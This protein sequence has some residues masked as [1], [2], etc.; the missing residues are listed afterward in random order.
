MISTANS[1]WILV[2]S[3]AWIQMIRK[4]GD[5]TI[6]KKVIAA[7]ED[8]SAAWCDLVRLELWRGA[9]SKED[10]E[11]LNRFEQQLPKLEISPAVWDMGS[12]MAHQCRKKGK[13]VPSTDLIV[14]A[15]AK[16]HQAKLLH[17]D[18]HFELLDSITEHS[19]D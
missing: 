12:Q 4:N 19:E 13:P 3:S 11:I 6:R 18:R 9:A 10:L 1:E 15:C 14:Y 5:S 7:M 17:R 8:G 2:D 16:T